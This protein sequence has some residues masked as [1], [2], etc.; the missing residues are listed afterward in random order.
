M[1]AVV[2][3]VG[4]ERIG[5]QALLAGVDMILMPADLDAAH[6]GI[7]DAVASGELTEARIDESVTRIVRAKLELLG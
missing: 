6:Q 2:E 5:V 4:S 1:G 3:E 7:L